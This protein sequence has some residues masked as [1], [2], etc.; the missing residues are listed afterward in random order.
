[1]SATS[2]NLRLLP[3]YDAAQSYDWN[4]A[5]APEP[6]E[7]DVPAIGGAWD[8]C[9]L[10]VASPLGIAAG[11][12][13]N[14]R[15]LR[16]YASLGFDVLTYKTVRSVERACYPMPNLV[17]VAVDA[18]IGGEREVPAAATMGRTW[19][20]SFGMPSK[21]PDVWRAD[22]EQ[23][24]KLLPKGKVLVVSVVATEQPGWTIDDMA[25]DYARCA[26]WAVESGADAVETNFSCP[27]VCTSDGQLY[28]QPADA[29]HCA[30]AVREAIGRVPY[31]VKIGHVRDAEEAATLTAAIG[32]YVDGL[33]MTNSVAAPVR[34]NNGTLLFDG[35][36]AGICGAAILEASLKQTRT[37]RQVV[38][39]RYLKEAV[40]PPALVGVGGAFSA[41]DVRRYLVAGA[42]AVHLATAVMVNPQIG[43]EVRANW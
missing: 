28:Q 24:R 38:T 41:E 13:L 33:A 31:L 39:Q 29:A 42:A 17:P 16:Y 23:T 4:Y 27:N 3:R 32:P 20:V 25:A 40:K 12:L 7:A 22:V 19:A 14:G 11:P 2:D 6:I 9:G 35:A 1:M 5:H 8:F 37:V 30:A 36:R 34:A 21:A 18:M 10:P 43:L 26:R 15:W